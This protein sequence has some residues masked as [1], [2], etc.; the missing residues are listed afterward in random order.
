MKYE[1][2]QRDII[3][4]D[5]LIEENPEFLQ[6]TKYVLS[7]AEDAFNK[8]KRFNKIKMTDNE[9]SNLAAD[10]YIAWNA[11]IGYKDLKGI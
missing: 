7:R 11:N 1:P 9:L 6:L 4:K 8:R 3:F 2:I 10:M 5:K